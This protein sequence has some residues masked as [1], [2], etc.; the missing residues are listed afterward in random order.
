MGSKVFHTIEG[1]AI[2]FKEQKHLEMARLMINFGIPG[3]DQISTLGINCKMNEF[4]AIMGLCV[5]DEMETILSER[6]KIWNKYASAFA[7][8]PNIKLQK[9][10][11]LSSQNYSYFPIVLESE[12]ILLKLKKALLEIEISPRRYFYPSLE[13]IPYVKQGQITPISADISKRI[14]CLPIYP[15]LESTIQDTII[16]NVNKITSTHG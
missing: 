14:L 4:Q 11:E 16:D 3:Y 15:L 13:Q 2:V 5:L 7:Y 12:L 9:Q 8:N 1:G 6:E 10:T